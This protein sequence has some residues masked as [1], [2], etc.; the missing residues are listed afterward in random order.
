M[1]KAK[2]ISNRNAGSNRKSDVEG[3]SLIGKAI[4]DLPDDVAEFFDVG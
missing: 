1:A 3:D 4:L 2:E